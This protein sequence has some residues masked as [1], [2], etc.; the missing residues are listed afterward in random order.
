M[1]ID[2]LAKK[3]KTNRIILIAGYIDSDKANKI[4]KELLQFSIEDDRKPIK[5]YI[6]SE[7]GN[8]L[9]AMSILDTMQSVGNPIHGVGIGMAS[10]YA[11]L[12][13]ACCDKGE[14][15]ALAHTKISFEQPYGVLNVGTNQETEI[16]IA[17][18]EVAMER[19]V[20]EQMLAMV[21]G[22]SIEK[23]HSDVENGL[24]MTVQEAIGYGMIDSVI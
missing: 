2:E 20:F 7:G 1:G 18:K 24:D 16:A 8:Y 4:V 17:A 22:N 14:R 23:I 12:L 15:K 10:N 5:L 19:E 3:L 13:I 21:T 9:D 6:A 11:A